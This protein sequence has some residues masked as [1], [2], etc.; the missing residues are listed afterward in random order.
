[1]NSSLR[2]LLE[3]NFRLHSQAFLPTRKGLRA[4]A[5]QGTRS[6]WGGLEALEKRKNIASA[7]NRTLTLQSSS[8]FLPKLRIA[9]LCKTEL[10]LGCQEPQFCTYMIL[11]SVVCFPCCAATAADWV[12]KAD[13]GE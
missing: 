1:M 11:K 6:M 8:K 13:G 12:L 2:D 7:G 3:E 5:E 4:P 9:I 10:V